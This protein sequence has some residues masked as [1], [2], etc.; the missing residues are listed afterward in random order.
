MKIDVEGHEVA[1]LDGM[2]QL[3][4]RNPRVAV[5]VEFNERTLAAAG[6]TATS[7]WSA[8]D[9]CGLDH[10]ALAGSP[11]LPVKFPKDLAII[12]SEIR[13]Q[14]NERVNLLCV[15]FDR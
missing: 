3:C 7:F 11:P 1:V 9:R 10:V 5:I 8:L 12:R 4:Q 6:E 2:R 14:G 13:R 15:Q